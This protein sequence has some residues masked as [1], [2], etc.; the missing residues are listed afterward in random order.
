M[1][2]TVTNR[3]LGIG[4]DTANG[5]SR[6]EAIGTALIYLNHGGTV[7]W[8]CYELPHV[9][10][11]PNCDAVLYST[12]TMRDLFGFRHDFDSATPSITCPGRPGIS[13]T[14]DGAGFRIPLAFVPADRPQPS[15]IVRAVACRAFATGPT[16]S[17]PGTAQSTL[18]HRLGFPYLDQWRRVP[19]S[20]T[21]HG[22]PAN[23]SVSSVPVSDAIVRGRSRALPVYKH[24]DGQQ[25]APG[26]PA[27]FSTSTAPRSAR[28]HGIAPW[29][30][31][32]ALPLALFVC[33]LIRLSCAQKE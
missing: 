33:P 21:G 23:S 16:H 13:I 3:S 9:L 15:S 20:I 7:G 28:H 5:F 22:L 31:R 29:Q 1:L 10:V 6:V 11:M 12:R 4:V 18:Y 27:E 2:R 24:L 25:P 26:D 30:R 17:G 19:E 8:A 14:D 32:A